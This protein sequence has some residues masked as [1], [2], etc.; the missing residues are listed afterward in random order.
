MS[1]KGKKK[2]LSLLIALSMV[3]SVLSGIGPKM[4]VKA[5]GTIK[6]NLTSLVQVKVG[7]SFTTLKLYKN[8]LYEAAE[9]YKAGS[10]SAELYVDG[11]A[12][13]VSAN[14]TTD[15]DGKV[16]FRFQNDSFNLIAE[17]DLPT[18]TLVGGFSKEEAEEDEKIYFLEG[19]NKRGIA[20]NPGVSANDLNYV[21]GGVYSRTFTIESSEKDRVVAD[22]GYKI[23]QDHSWDI[24]YGE[25]SGNIQ[26]TIPAGVDKLTIMLD[27]FSGKVYDSVNAGTFDIAQNSGAVTADKLGRTV[28]LIGP[29]RE[30]GDDNWNPSVNGF[31]FTQISD[32][33][34]IYQKIFAKKGT[35]EYKVVIDGSKWYEAEEGNQSLTTTKVNQN[36]VFLYDASTGLL[37]DSTNKEEA[38][39]IASSLGVAASGSDEGGE[40]G[41]DEGGETGGET[42]GDQG[43]ETG[44]ETSGSVST[45]VKSLVEVKVGDDFYTLPIVSSNNG[46]GVYEAKVSLSG[47]IVATL[48]VDGSE[49]SLTTNVSADGDVI[50]RFA[51]GN[52]E[53]L[54]ASTIPTETL[55]GGFASHDDNKILFKDGDK[56]K[57]VK[58]NQTDSSNDLEYI[59]GGIYSRTFTLE[60]L[61]DD[62]EVPDGG[63]KVAENHDWSVCYGKGSDNMPLTIPAGTKSLTIR[64]DR[65]SGTLYDS[66]NNPEMFTTKDYSLVGTVRCAG[67]DNWAAGKTGYEFTQLNDQ[68]FVKQLKLPA[69]ANYEYKV[70][71]NHSAWG[72]QGKDGNYSFGLLEDGAVTFIY[73]AKNDC[74]YDSVNDEEKVAEILGV[75]V[76][77][78]KASVN[79]NPNGTTL[80]TCPASEGSKVTVTVINAADT[81]DVKTQELNYAG[82]NKFQ[83]SIFLGDAAGDF[84]FIFTIN[85]KEVVPDGFETVKVSDKSYAVYSKDEFKGRNVY[86]P[87]TLPGP[88]WDAGSNKM[89]YKGNL[90]YECVFKAVPAANY[91]YKIAIDGSWSENYGLNGI[92][93]GANVPIA[94]PDTMDIIISYN[95]MSHN[96]VDNVSYKFTTV[97]LYGPGIP[98]DTYLTDTTL[99]GIYSVAVDLTAGTYSGITAEDADGNKYVY[100]DFTLKEDKKVTFY[101][102]PATGI[103]YNDASDE[104]VDPEGVKYDTKDKNY[105]SIYGAIPTDTDVTFTIDVPDPNVTSVKMVLKGKNQKTIDMKKVEGKAQFAAT[106]QF[107]KLG[108]SDY[109][110]VLSNG[111]SISVYSDIDQDTDPY[112]VGGITASLAEAKPYDLIVYDKN[113]KTP[114][115]MKNA[116]IYQIF[117]DRFCNGDK[118]NDKAQEYSRGDIRYEFI[119]DWNTIPE[120]PEQEALLDEDVYKSTGAYY[121]D[122]VWSDEI[123]GGDIKGI[124][125][126]VDY[127]DALGVN[128]IY[129]NPCFASISSHRYDTSDYKLIDPVLGTNGDFEELV[130]VA[131]AHDMK[132]IL[133]GVFNH[134]SDD[135]IYFDRYY[136]YLQD[137]TTKIGAYPY[138]AYVYD[139][140]AEDESLTKEEAE[141]KAKTYFTENYGITD[142]TY[143]AWV[144]VFQSADKYLKNDD[145]EVVKDTVGLRAGKPVY[146]YDGW[147]GYD[148]MPVIKSTNGSE[149]QTPGWADEIIDGEGCVT[150]FWL[151]EG[152]SGWRLDVANEVS[153]ETWQK[154]RNSV[155]GL[156]SENVIVG[157]IWTDATQYLLGDMYDSVMNYVFRGAVIGFAG[158][159]DATKMMNTLEKLRERYPE[160]AFYAMMNLVGSHDTS[161][162]LS[163]LD[164][165]GDDRADKSISGAFPTYEGTSEAA[166]EKQYLVAFLQF[167]YP[168][169]PT[170]YYGDELGM[171]GGDDPDN[172]RGMIWGLGAK[173]LTEY[174]AKLGQIRHAYS[175]LNTGDIRYFD[176]NDNTVAGYV[177]SDDN[178]NIIVLANS[179]EGS[180]SITVDLKALNIEDTSFTDVMT[181][182]TYDAVEDRIIVS[183]A[184]RR[185]AIL[186]PSDSVKE[187]S[188]D[189][190]SLSIGYDESKAESYE[191]NVPTTDYYIT[192][193]TKDQTWS[194]KSGKGLLIISIAP[195]EKFKGVEVDGKEID[196]SNYE[197]SRG[198]TRITLKAEYLEKLDNG[199]HNF[200]ILSTDGAASTTFTVKDAEAQLTPDPDPAKD[201]DVTPAKDADTSD[202]TNKDKTNSDKPQ[203]GDTVNLMLWFIIMFSSAGIA[204]MLFVISKKRKSL[205]E[206]ED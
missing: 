161:R 92:A 15:E 91:E 193:A 55:V 9:N 113:F 72:P 38:S 53:A 39:K 74:M 78:V 30:T 171:V 70:I 177:R 144:D 10:Y 54:T 99:Q 57:E 120:N 172:R 136:K 195:F 44:G 181:G 126:R 36:V 112:G 102:D 206:D 143:T 108:E 17:K 192:D 52:F 186:V 150:H 139:L 85:E 58:W 19:E 40:T 109:F 86:V 62:F 105:K 59:G 68:Y 34:F 16:Y 130:Q 147:W 188:V 90:L 101:L 129:I 178:A 75:E 204:A 42:G 48:Y 122:R 131:E 14:V 46:Q 28:S 89:T 33:L 12:T 197:A 66:I 61:D 180:K 25:G 117:P 170:I 65:N 71:Y 26:L 8:G 201:A 182:E 96:M 3:V 41:G 135:S 104:K 29:A 97:K 168:G 77:H 32:N 175:T 107:D 164:G 35:Y 146:G 162:L 132:I 95:D 51:N 7:D 22:G 13:G 123:Y 50:F 179:A 76:S 167:T 155:K 189:E 49:T 190:D 165:V 128:V 137:G 94:V 111:S 4:V 80:F 152:S 149:Y 198:S 67:D 200:T 119:T 114:D 6:T 115:W 174:Y 141:N 176:T 27:S 116:V 64:L 11:N 84:D 63:Y 138:W 151:D 2:Y 20:W 202:T 142:Y 156:D 24:S 191:A 194:K 37:Y 1:M 18:E 23:A 47:D 134:V 185:G 106:T 125:D 157:E 45:N 87:G 118:S 100:A 169:A 166:K 81:K 158:D 160:E 43:G 69:A 205:L 187:V 93:S 173:D 5:E 124:I 184:S 199:V 133:D 183:V 110:F 159:Q 196:S 127:L 140:M 79:Q 203:T 82:N 31:E 153:D 148:N 56:T 163:M 121:G 154:F 73:D 103:Y 83:G 88:S 60:S 21:G 98:D 145:G